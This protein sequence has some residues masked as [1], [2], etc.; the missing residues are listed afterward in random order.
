MAKT[1]ITTTIELTT[2][3]LTSL[4][5][6][7]FKDKK[8]LDVTKVTYKVSDT[9]DDRFGGYPSYNLTKIE[10]INEVNEDTII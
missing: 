10:I 3:Q 2:E 4:I 5:K 1:T 8:G 6:G 7:Y 9:S